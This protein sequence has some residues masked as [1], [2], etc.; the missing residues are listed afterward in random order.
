E[1]SVN[2]YDA[3]HVDI[4]INIG[5]KNGSQMT[6]VVA[7]MIPQLARPP[8]W[9]EETLRRVSAQKLRVLAVG[10]LTLD[11]EHRLRNVSNPKDKQR[12]RIA[13]WEIHPIT[14]FFVCEQATCDPV[15][16]EE[17]TTLQSW[18]AKHLQ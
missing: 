10:S 6:G 2:C 14:E 3:N 8:G 18:K 11:T 7:E 13:L 12:Q 17:W 4:H 1:E 9:D 5:P 16:H 15:A